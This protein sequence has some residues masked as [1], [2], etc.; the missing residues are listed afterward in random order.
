MGTWDAQTLYENHCIFGIGMSG[1]RQR[2]WWEYMEDKDI[3]KI[4]KSA[5]KRRSMQSL[6]ENEHL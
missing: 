1:W 4:T 2:D 3:Q 6:A 5:R